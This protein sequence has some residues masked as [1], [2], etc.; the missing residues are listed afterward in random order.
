MQN[1]NDVFDTEGVPLSREGKVPVWLKVLFWVLMAW[2]LWAMIAFWSGSF[3][4]FDRGAWH[5]LQEAAHTTAPP[6]F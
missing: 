4:W 2:G 3:G 5:A 1:E 6:K